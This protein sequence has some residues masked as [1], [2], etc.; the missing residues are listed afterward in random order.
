MT[1]LCGAG[2]YGDAGSERLL[3]EVSKPVMGIGVTRHDDGLWLRF[4]ANAAISLDSI[5]KTSGS[6]VERNVREF[7]TLHAS[8]TAADAAP[9]KNTDV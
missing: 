4:G 2:H 9:K 8:T 6:I 5:L 7:C 1:P 3:A